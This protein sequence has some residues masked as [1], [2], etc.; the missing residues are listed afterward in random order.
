MSFHIWLSI[1]VVVISG[2]M[3]VLFLFLSTFS[4]R[5]RG[6]SR[7]MINAFFF[8]PAFYLFLTWIFTPLLQ[9]LF[10]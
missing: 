6:R 9:L 2:M 4:K 7:Q 8:F 10:E 1:G 3:I 5:I